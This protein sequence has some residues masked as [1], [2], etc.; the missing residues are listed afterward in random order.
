MIS[1]L[2]ATL[3]LTA[4]LTFT[5]TAYQLEMKEDRGGAM[6]SNLLLHHK[7][8]V[9]FAASGSMTNGQISDVLT[10]PFREMDDWQTRVVSGGHRTVVV[11]YV[12]GG[13]EEASRS[14]L[15]AFSLITPAHLRSLPESYA[16]MYMYSDSGTGGS[17][18]MG[19][20]SDMNL[21]MEDESP[22]LI[23]VIDQFYE[24]PA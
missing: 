1:L 16:G 17:I 12:P 2:P 8:S 3:M 22:A 14:T 6:S 9:E 23:T 15:K 13:S 7:K 5:L 18:G 10:G 19:D 21:P 24:P 4:A 11:T 20:F